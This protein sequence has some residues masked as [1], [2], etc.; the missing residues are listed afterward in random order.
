MNE[1]ERIKEI[2]AIHQEIRDATPFNWDG[3][4]Q[5]GQMVN[6][7]GEI[8]HI[9]FKNRNAV[10]IKLVGTN[11]IKKIVNPNRSFIPPKAPVSEVSEYMFKTEDLIRYSYSL[12]DIM[13]WFQGFI[14]ARG[15]DFKLPIDIDS[16]RELNIKIRDMIR[17]A[18]L[19]KG[20]A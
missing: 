12:S 13:C 16:A 6:I 9:V 2:K 18:S 17:L 5:H 20:A 14:A 7:N 15:G 10:K 4:Y 11:T 1:H 3:H 8:G 19:S